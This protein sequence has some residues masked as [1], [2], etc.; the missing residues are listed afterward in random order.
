[1]TRETLNQDA[2]KKEFKKHNSENALGGGSVT[3]TPFLSAYLP[4]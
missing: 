1:M 3:D 2:L 4:L